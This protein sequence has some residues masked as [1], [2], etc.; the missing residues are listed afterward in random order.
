MFG[1]FGFSYVGLIFLLM[2]FL[3]NLLWIKRQPKGYEE[4]AKN[5]NKVFLAFEHIG[6][7][8]VVVIAVIF[9]DYNISVITPWIIWFLVACGC[10]LLYEIAWIRYFYNP[11]LKNFY[12][13][14]LFI[15]I[16]LASLP[17]L[18]FLFLGIYGKVIW[19]LLAVII[20]GIGHLGIHIQHIKTLKNKV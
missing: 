2:L 3:P 11:S 1:H 6:Q 14:L 18:A 7:I 19:L 17:V 20:F 10:M 16:P 5:E 13:R 8:A 4:L 9:N 12:V 15:P